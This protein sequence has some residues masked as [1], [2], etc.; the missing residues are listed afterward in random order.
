[1]S[2]IAIEWAAR[3][4]V[5]DQDKRRILDWLAERHEMGA[6]LR[7]SLPNLGG[8]FGLT[9][10]AIWMVLTSFMHGGLIRIPSGIGEFATLELVLPDLD[11]GGDE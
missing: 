10:A 2:D 7:I 11:E 3:Q 6:P 4:Q 1:M 9:P 8:Q 5:E